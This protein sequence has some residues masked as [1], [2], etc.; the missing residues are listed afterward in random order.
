VCILYGNS[1]GS[2]VIIDEEG[3]VLTAAHVIRDYP[4]PDPKKKGFTDPAPLPFEAGKDVTIQLH[5]GTKVKGKT[6][7]INAK[8][9]S[10]M[11]R[12]TEKPKSGGK[13][14]FAPLAKSGDLQKN[15]WVVALGHPNGPRVGRPPVA[16]LGRIAGMSTSSLRTEC[17]L[18]GGDS[19]GPLFDL[20]GKVIGIHS[21]IGPWLDN[22][23]HVPADA[24]TKEWDKLFAGEWVDKPGTTGK[25]PGK[26]YVAVVFPDDDEDDAWL[27]EVEPKGP[28]DKAGLKAGDTITKWNDTAVKSVKQFRKLIEAAKPGDKI[29]LTIRRGTEV[30]TPTLTLGER[31]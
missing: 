2:G 5:D 30:L 10:G 3:T 19:G 25:T 16:R 12:I 1:T 14:P 8:M 22:N 7:G 27:R 26:A 17:T 18:V 11:V 20:N 13:W 31:P 9:D 15:Q 21:R 23:I 4:D 28:A 29:K 6:L 24:Y